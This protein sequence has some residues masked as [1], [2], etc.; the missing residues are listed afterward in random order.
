MMEETLSGY[1]HSMMLMEVWET[2][3]EPFGWKVKEGICEKWSWRKFRLLWQ[4]VVEKPEPITF[5]EVIDNKSEVNTAKQ[6]FTH[7]GHMSIHIKEFWADPSNH[8]L[9]KSFSEWAMECTQKDQLL[10]KTA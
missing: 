9:T 4:M 8:D 5:K 7:Y 2:S 3:Y 10:L 1:R 6:I